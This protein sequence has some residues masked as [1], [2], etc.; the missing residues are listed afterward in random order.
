MLIIGVIRSYAMEDDSMSEMKD[1]AEVL[2]RMEGE[3]LGVVAVVTVRGGCTTER[4]VGDKLS[5]RAIV[6][7]PE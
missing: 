4:L 2:H 5:L 1:P 7:P 3:G 6:P